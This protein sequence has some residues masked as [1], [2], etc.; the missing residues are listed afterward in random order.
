[1]DFTFTHLAG[2]TVTCNTTEGFSTNVT[3][4]GAS[5]RS[6]IPEK[7]DSIRNDCVSIVLFKAIFYVIR[8]S[9]N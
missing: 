6:G 2:K 7:D 5:M 8:H 1:M 4:G 9:R 3:V